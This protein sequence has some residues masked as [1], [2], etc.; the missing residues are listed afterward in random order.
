MEQDTAAQYNEVSSQYG[1]VARSLLIRELEWNAMANH[2]GDLAGRS[3]LDLACGS[4]LSSRMLKQWGAGRVVGVDFAEGMLAQARELERSQPLGIEYRQA[5]AANI[6]DIGPF[7]LVTASYYLCYARDRDHLFR[8]VQVAY[9]NLA[10]GQR[11]ITT[12]PHPDFP[13]DPVCDL[14]RYG[15]IMRNQAPPLHEGGMLHVKLIL[16]GPEPMEVEFDTRHYS[17]A[18]YDAAIRQAGFTSWRIEPFA[19]S[20]ALEEEHG[21]EFWDLYRAQPI[22]C[23]FIC[24][25]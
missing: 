21:S 15:L 16:D 13:P 17:R 19:I 14:A 7:D 18:T 8:M 9:D 10:P 11:F 2:V 5:D 22:V 12:N 1:K 6:G 24:Q 4:G 23:H 25:K 3:A 20:P